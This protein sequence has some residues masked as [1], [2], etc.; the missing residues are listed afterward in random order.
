MIIPKKDGGVP[1]S[2]D[3]TQQ[4]LE[5]ESGQLPM[6]HLRLDEERVVVSFELSKVALE[7]AHLRRDPSGPG[8]HLLSQDLAWR[9]RPSLLE[10]SAPTKGALRLSKSDGAFEFVRLPGP[11][12]GKPE[13]AH[14]R[15]A[16]FLSKARKAP[17]EELSNVQAG[18]SWEIR[19]RQGD[20][21]ACEIYLFELYAR[22]GELVERLIAETP[23]LQSQDH[24]CSGLRSIEAQVKHVYQETPI[25]RF[26]LH[27]DA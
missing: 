22:G 14:T 6:F 20:K 24:A 26:L 10:A 3:S 1:A 27:I 18:G 12:K 19:K 4:N 13:V 8:R 16:W 7:D 23:L 15:D 17:E 5:P 9:D 21:H 11:P 2:I 25:A